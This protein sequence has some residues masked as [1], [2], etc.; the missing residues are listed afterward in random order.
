[1]ASGG[2]GSVAPQSDT[3][4]QGSCCRVR[5]NGGVCLSAAAWWGLAARCAVVLATWS[6]TALCSRLSPL[7]A[8]QQA[9]GGVLEATDVQRRRQ[10]LHARQLRRLAC[11]RPSSADINVM[12]TPSLSS[13]CSSHCCAAGSTASLGKGACLQKRLETRGRSCCRAAGWCRHRPN[14]QSI[15]A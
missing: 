6:R 8:G 5:Q 2:F 15:G 1:M 13:R 14:R 10:R 9:G 7:E 4:R 11:G 12:K 3:V